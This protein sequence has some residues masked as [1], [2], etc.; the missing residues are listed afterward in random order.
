MSYSFR[1]LLV[2]SI[3]GLMI[4]ACSGPNPN[5]KLKERM[6]PNPDNQKLLDDLG[7]PKV[8]G[9]NAAIE[10]SA[11]KA[12]DAKQYATAAQY[13]AQLI[14]KKP[15]EKSYQFAMA[16]SLRRSG[17][18]E[19]SIVQYKKLLNDP[20]YDIDAKEGLGLA[21]I[22]LGEFEEAGDALAEVMEKEPRRWRTVN[23]IGI[24]FTT[25]QMY[26]EAR[27]YFEEALSLEPQNVAVR[28]N[29]ALME[30]MDKQY[31]RS[32]ILLQ[33]ASRIAGRQEPELKRMVDLNLALVYAV[34]GNLAQAEAVSR[35]HLTEVQRLNNMGLYA[36]LEG[37]D[38]LARSYL[39]MALT[40][41][42]KHYEKAWSN[43]E[44]IKRL[45]NTAPEKR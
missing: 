42:S 14:E 1:S 39:D 44:T 22:S 9:M 17:K 31:D 2:V 10:N 12:F 4:S 23:A 24:L 6:Q 26:P 15:D 19:H 25:K 38:M 3:C 33:D 28:N 37:D 45:R 16:E 13:Y 34:Q 41:S 7:G 43:L 27:R 30:A 5:L 29:M 8:E 21:Y 35:P 32:T 20:K 18:F 36:S 11:K 40:Q